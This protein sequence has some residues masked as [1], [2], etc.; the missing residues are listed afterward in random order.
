MSMSLLRA[1]LAEVRTAAHETGEVDPEAIACRRGLSRD[2]VAAMVD[3]WIYRGRL[4]APLPGSPCR[5]C[6]LAAACGP[7]DGYGRGRTACRPG[8]TEAS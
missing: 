8:L 5:G 2:E 4:P 3:Y 1:V 7:S 6:G